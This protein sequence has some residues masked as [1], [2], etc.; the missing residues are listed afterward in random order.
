MVRLPRI[1]SNGPVYVTSTLEA[2]S[3][4]EITKEGRISQDGPSDQISLVIYLEKISNDSFIR[5]QVIVDVYQKRRLLASELVY[6]GP[7]NA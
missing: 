7:S 3:L 2:N 1:S 5:A 6:L 4:V